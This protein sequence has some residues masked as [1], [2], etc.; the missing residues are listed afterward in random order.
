MK[1]SKLKKIRAILNN[2]AS[3]DNEKEICRKLLAKHPE[4]EKPQRVEFQFSPTFETDEQAFRRQNAA[5]YQKGFYNRHTGQDAARRRAAADAQGASR[6]Q[7]AQNQQ[8]HEQRSGQ[9]SGFYGGLGGVFG[10]FGQAQTPKPDYSQADFERAQANINQQRAAQE[11][12]IS[13]ILGENF[14]LKLAKKI[15]GDKRGTNE[16]D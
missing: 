11:K 5:A 3:T 6:Q 4:Q 13:K 9:A 10:G 16:G 2:P 8:Q 1:S 15:R 7:A 12:N 14:L